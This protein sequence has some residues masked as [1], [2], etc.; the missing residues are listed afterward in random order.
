MCIICT[1][2]KCLKSHQEVKSAVCCRSCCKANDEHMPIWSLDKNW[3]CAFS[4]YEIICMFITM[5]LM[6][7]WL[8]SSYETHYTYEHFLKLSIKHTIFWSHVYWHLLSFSPKP[9]LFLSVSFPLLS[10]SSGCPGEA[11]VTVKVRQW[12]CSG[13]SRKANNTGKAAK[14]PV[15]LP[16]ALKRKES[17]TICLKDVWK[18]PLDSLA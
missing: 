15:D 4:L 14:P 8:K 17:L 6:K 3:I 9:T 10:I 11:P 1:Y 13:V 18:I 7:E 5:F 12:A 16:K 2:D